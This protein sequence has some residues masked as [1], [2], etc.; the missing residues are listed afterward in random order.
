MDEEDKSLALACG[1]SLITNKLR[2]CGPKDAYT[3][4]YNVI[5]GMD[6]DKE[7]IK[8]H[9]MRYE[10]LYVYL[11]GIAD[12][13][14]KEMFDYDVVESY[15]I[16][17]SLLDK[18]DANALKKMVLGLA[19]RG[20][21]EKYAKKMAK[22]MPSGMN[23]HHSFNVLYV[24]VGMTTGSVPTNIKTMNSCIVSVGKVVKI[25]NDKLTLKLSPIEIGGDKLM[26]GKETM[27][28]VAYNKEFLPGLK[29]NDDVAVHWGYA[30]KILT[31]KEVF[32]LKKYTQKNM[33][34]LNRAKF[35]SSA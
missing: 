25:S 28:K 17:N 14:R 24:G 27:K 26:F 34:A 2:Y 15:W 13:S 8:K 5:K 1:F 6:Y 20:L 32:S 35:F 11:K 22:Q 30:C 3:D 21:P 18:F 10:G 7:K 23:P 31:K 33:D 9:L 19:K 12:K 29:K 4:F 16:G